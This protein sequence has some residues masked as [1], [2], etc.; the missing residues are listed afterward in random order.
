MGKKI[1]LLSHLVLIPISILFL[2]P[3]LLLISTALKSLPEL[4][5]VD[6]T[7][8]PRK[9]ILTNFPEALRVAPFGRYYINTIL[10]VL[11]ILGVQ[12]VT[13]SLAAYAFARLTFPGRDLLFLLLLLQ[14]MI[15]PQSI[16]VPNYITISSLKLLDTK[17]AVGIIYFASAFGTFL[18][19]QAFRA[20]PRDMEDAAK[21][22]GCSALQTIYYVFVPL[23]RPSLIAFSLASI[24]FHW[25]EFFWPLIVTD[26]IKAR[27]L[28]VGLA[29][30]TQATESSPEWT[31]TMAATLIV[32]FPLLVT[33]LIF[34]RKFIQSFMLTGIKG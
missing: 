5:N 19:R 23:T 16:V 4:M 20:I 21:M 1:H 28:T 6:F 10:I 9:I 11:G 22:D 24:I 18:M 12:L 32:V 34:Q 33:F 15:P 17:L 8:I 29:M 13:I 7:W 3:L 30:L 31:L 25:N 2:V 27:T 14:L 26:T